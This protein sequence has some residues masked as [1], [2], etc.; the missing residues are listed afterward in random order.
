[1]MRETRASGVSVE[2]DTAVRHAIAPQENLG[3]SLP[4]ENLVPYKTKVCDLGRVAIGFTISSVTNLSIKLFIGR[5][6]QSTQTASGSFERRK[7]GK[8]GSHDAPQTSWT[9]SG[10]DR[11]SSTL[12]RWHH[13]PLLRTPKLRVKTECLPLHCCAAVF[14]IRRAVSPP[15]NVRNPPRPCDCLRWAHREDF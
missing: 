9:G 10:P 4:R 12:T 14:F 1:M 13:L 7:R 8:Q 5:Q 3:R 6:M 2:S 11:G 15:T